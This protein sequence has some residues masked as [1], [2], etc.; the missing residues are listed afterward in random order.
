[1]K[2]GKRKRE[3]FKKKK[4]QRRRNELCKCGD[5]ERRRGLLH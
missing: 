2:K 5:E 1:M 3:P 4:K